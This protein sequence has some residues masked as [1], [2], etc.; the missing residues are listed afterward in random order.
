VSAAW[1]P[2]RARALG[3][4]ACVPGWGAYLARPGRGGSRRSWRLRWWARAEAPALSSAGAGRTFGTCRAR[5]ARAQTAN[6]GRAGSER[7]GLDTIQARLKRSSEEA[8]AARK[9]V[10]VRVRITAHTV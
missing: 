9:A 3:T 7:N 2:Q 8:E 10:H 1:R 5:S 4:R 6:G